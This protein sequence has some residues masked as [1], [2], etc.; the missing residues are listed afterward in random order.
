MRSKKATVLILLIFCTRVKFWLSCQ[1]GNF[2]ATQPLISLPYRRIREPWWEL[3]M[4]DPTKLVQTE[5]G[6]ECRNLA[7]AQLGPDL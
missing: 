2:C 5:R 6:A 1:M 4:Q 3:S 7:G